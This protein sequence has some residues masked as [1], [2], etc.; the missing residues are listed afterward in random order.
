MAAERCETVTTGKG[1]QVVAG[2]MTGY[3][4]TST[5]LSLLSPLIST[6]V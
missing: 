4:F 2:V 6:V 1:T 5:S 3:S